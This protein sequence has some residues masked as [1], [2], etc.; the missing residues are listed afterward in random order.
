[1]PLSAPPRLAAVT[2]ARGFDIDCVLVDVCKQLSQ[3]GVRLG[4]LLQISTGAKGGGCASTV[5]VVDLRSNTAF[6]IWEERGACAKGCRL[7]ERGLADA[8]SVIELALGDRVDLI[9]INRFGRAE[10]LGRGLLSCFASALLANVP[11]LTAVR[12][13]YDEAWRTF[14]GGCGRE[15]AT[16]IREIVDWAR[17]A[18]AASHNAYAA[19]RRARGIGEAQAGG[20]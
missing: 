15:I 10:S 17:D 16:E 13:P 9:V 3:K 12:P 20:L 19:D 4:G 2:Y 18:T 8:A 7:D 6:D 5:H 1:M 14:H 11:V